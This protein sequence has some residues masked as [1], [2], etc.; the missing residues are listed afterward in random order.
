MVEDISEP[1]E[2]TNVA[3]KTEPQ[4]QETWNTADKIRGSFISPFKRTQQPVVLKEGL[5][6]KPSPGIVPSDQTFLNK[7]SVNSGQFTQ[8]V[9]NEENTGRKGMSHLVKYVETSIVIKMVLTRVT[10]GA[11]SLSAW[12][13]SQS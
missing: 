4:K 6:I 11:A 12:P 1:S 3:A 7:I 8:F 13:R 2:G 5:R 9:P 10:L